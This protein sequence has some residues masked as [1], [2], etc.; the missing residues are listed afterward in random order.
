LCPSYFLVEGERLINGETCPRE[1]EG[2][3][4]H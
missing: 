4:T 2:Q 1:G 3:W